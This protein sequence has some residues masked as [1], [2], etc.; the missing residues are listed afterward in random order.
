[1]LKRTHRRVSSE[2]IEPEAVKAAHLA[3]TKWG[4]ISVSVP[5][6]AAGGVQTRVVNWLKLT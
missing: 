6:I 4:T 3:D 5:A 2:E 1:M